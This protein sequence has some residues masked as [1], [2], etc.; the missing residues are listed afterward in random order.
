MK[1][2]VVQG[3]KHSIRLLKYLQEICQEIMECNSSDVQMSH[4]AKGSETTIETKIKT[5]GSQTYNLYVNKC[6]SG[7]DPMET[8]KIMLLLLLSIGN[9]GETFQELRTIG[10][11]YISL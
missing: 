4:C 6:V 7:P 10:A 3:K 11:D 1:A 2:L 8:R 5:L 9:L